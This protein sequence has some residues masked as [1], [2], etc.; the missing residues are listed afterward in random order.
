MSQLFKNKYRINSTRLQYWNYANGGCYFIT[1]CTKKHKHYFGSLVE[2]LQCN[3]PTRQTKCLEF[4][5]NQ[6][7]YQRIIRPLIIGDILKL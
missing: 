1:V 3:V 4:H 6:S 7:H 2:T 5:R